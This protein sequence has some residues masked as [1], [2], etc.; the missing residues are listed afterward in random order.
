MAQLRAPWRFCGKNI[1]AFIPMVTAI[2]GIANCIVSAW[3]EIIGDPTFADAILDCIGH[4]SYRLVL[5]GQLMRNTQAESTD[6]NRI[7]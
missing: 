2:A 6:K 7:T 4:N 1:A 3:H 5:D